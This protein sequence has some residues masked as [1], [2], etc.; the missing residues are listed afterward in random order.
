MATS[1]QTHTHAQ[2]SMGLTYA[3]PNKDESRTH[4]QKMCMQTCFRI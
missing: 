3:C 2:C 4:A 1:M